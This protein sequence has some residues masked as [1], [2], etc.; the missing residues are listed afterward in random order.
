LLV[1]TA[2]RGR[3][4]PLEVGAAVHLIWQSDKAFVFPRPL[5]AVSS[6]SE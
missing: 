2:E 4:G 1:A 5:G 3:S 6:S